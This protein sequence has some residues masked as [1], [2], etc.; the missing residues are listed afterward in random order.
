[1]SND[2][3]NGGAPQSQGVAPAQESGQPQPTGAAQPD[4][5]KIDLTSLPQFRTYQSEADRKTAQLQAQ[6]QQMQSR[7][8]QQEAEQQK[9]KRASMSKLDPEERAALLEQELERRDA[10]MAANDQ[11]NRLVSQVTQI[12]QSAGLQFNDPRL[13]DVLSGDPSIEGV[14]MIATR[15]ANIV[16]QDADAARLAM[17]KVQEDAQV[18]AK[19]QANLAAQQARVNALNDAGVTVTSSATPTVIAPASEKDKLVAAIKAKQKAARGR[20]PESQEHRAFLEAFH[21]SGLS[22]ADLGY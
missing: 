14:A 15:V 21:Q 19:Q 5:S 20:G 12:I 8:A 22:W 18:N 7:I 17:S 6:L 10:Q 9:V 11:R 2:V 1:M 3:S 16:R 13:A 4:L